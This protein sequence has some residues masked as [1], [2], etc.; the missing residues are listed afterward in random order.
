V[1]AAV[2][3]VGDPT[4]LDAWSA[5]VGVAPT[6]LR[7]R[8]HDAR[9]SIAASLSLCRVLRAVLLA[10]RLSWHISDVLGSAARG[11]RLLV[12]AGIGPGAGLSLGE[13]LQ[14]Q[15]FTRRPPNVAAIMRQVTTFLATE[16][17]PR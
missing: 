9:V 14:L 6:R 3:A 2:H 13:F 8:C 5:A 17:G 10:A 11:R 16:W 4:T 7:A 15:R 1:V 12:K